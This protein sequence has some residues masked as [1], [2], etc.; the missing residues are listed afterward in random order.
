MYTC[1]MAA[2]FDAMTALMNNGVRVERAFETAFPGHQY[3]HSTVGDNFKA[4]KNALKEAGAVD[5]A[6]R[7]GRTRAGEWASFRKRWF[8]VRN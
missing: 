8:K 1:D 4:Y 5:A 7:H 3:K 6:V 2:G